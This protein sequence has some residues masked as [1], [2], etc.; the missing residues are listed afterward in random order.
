MNAN[1]FYDADTRRVILFGGRD[2]AGT[3]FTDLWAL[4]LEGPLR[5]TALTAT[6]VPPPTRGPRAA[7][8]DP[9]RRRLTVFGDGDPL[10]PAENSSIWR[11]D[12]GAAPAWSP[13]LPAGRVPWNRTSAVALWDAAWDQ[14]IL[15]WGALGEAGSNGIWDVQRLV[16]SPDSPTP[17]TFALMDLQTAPG[18]VRLSWY[19]GGA[20]ATLERRAGDGAWMALARLTPGKDGLLGYEDRDVRPGGR[21]GYRL[22]RGPGADAISAEAWAEVPAAAAASLALAVPRPNPA[23][24]AVEVEFTLPRAGPARLELMDVAGRTVS[25][26]TLEG[27]AGPQR[28]R[29]ELAGRAPGLYFLRLAHDG[30]TLTRRVVV[31]R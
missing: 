4:E 18:L 12:L 19:T 2:S 22:R 21:Y 13:L 27:A 31:T 10:A 7:V 24:E 30:V 23:R 3:S 17:V 8:F 29:L 14:A 16:S 11:L 28:V 1:A 15:L 20:A 26:R 9:M 5:W 25:A 6:G